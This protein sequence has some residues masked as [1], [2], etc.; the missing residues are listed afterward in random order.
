LRAGAFHKCAAEGASISFQ[1]YK[2][3]LKR[4]EAGEEPYASFAIKAAKARADDAMRSIS[5]IE[6]AQLRRPRPED[7]QV[8]GDWKAAAWLLEH[9]YPQ[10]FGSA[11]LQAAAASMRMGAVAAKGGDDVGNE[12]G[13]IFYLPTNGRRPQDEP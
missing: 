3:W 10:E 11:A 7:G 12:N 9:K 2:N 8:E 5:V 1:T 6:R 4:G 13:V